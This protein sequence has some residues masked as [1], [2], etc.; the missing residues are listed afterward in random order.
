MQRKQNFAEW[1][2]TMLNEWF[3]FLSSWFCWGI[4]D[5]T[6]QLLHL[7]SPR[8]PQSVKTLPRDEILTIA[9]QRYDLIESPDR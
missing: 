1:K 8:L 2:K 6:A 4:D 5:F 9:Y 7:L 3:Y